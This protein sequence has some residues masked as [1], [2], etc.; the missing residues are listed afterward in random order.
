ML[1]AGV[2][3]SSFGATQ[4]LSLGRGRGSNSTN[5]LSYQNSNYQI[6]ENIK[7]GIGEW[8]SV[9]GTMTNSFQAGF[10]YQDESRDTRGGDGSQRGG[11]QADCPRGPGGRC[12]RSRRR[13]E[14][15][16]RAGRPPLR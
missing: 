12:G 16:C 2:F 5:F 7:S 4:T 1:L 8:N 6:L 15:G 14:V 11:P 10:T 9:F 13:T 3:G